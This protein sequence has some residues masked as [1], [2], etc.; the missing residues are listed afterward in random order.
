MS[1]IRRLISPV[2]MLASFALAAA[3]PAAAGPAITIYSRDLTLVREKRT[4]EVRGAR[5][6]VRLTDLTQ[7]LDFTSLRFVPASGRVTR[8]AWRPAQ[9]GGDELLGGYAIG[10]RVRVTTHADRTLEG[11][12]LSSDG[13]WLVIRGDDGSLTTIARANA[14]EV[15][16]A[17]APASLIGRPTL[18]AVIEGSSQARQNAELSY[19]TS[20][21]SW[22]AEHVLV[23]KGENAGSWSA[24]VTVANNTGRDFVDAD[25]ELVAGEPHRESEGPRPMLMGAMAKSSMAAAEAA[26]DLSE[27]AFSEYHL[28]TLDRPATLR[29][30]E[31]QSLSM[32]SPKDVKLTPRYLYRGGDAR[33]VMSQI[34]I[35]NDKAS[36]PGV[37]L[38]GGR[39]RIYEAQDS[40]ALRLIGESRI[41]HTAA[42]EKIT[43]DVGT[44]FDLAAERRQTADHRIADREREVSFEILL[45]NRKDT[46]VTIV[47]EEPVTG[48]VEV[49]A[50]THEFVRKDAHTLQFTIPVAA[51]KEV[52]LAYT[53]HMRY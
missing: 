50:K 10:R 37:P 46:G 41:S 44:A 17:D 24:G 7:G 1:A 12:L 49:T 6:T 42:G 19:L 16:L 3:T 14:E 2:A 4:I 25:L 34:E 11:A 36:G 52:K 27:Q 48:D 18:E 35:V 8:L 15:R 22:N 43:L 53:A 33:G 21:L 30:R 32:I 47:V 20:G 31:A 38:P 29:D 23:R 45:R 28:Y 26:P 40:G 13:S 5:D 51:G 39:V 9:S